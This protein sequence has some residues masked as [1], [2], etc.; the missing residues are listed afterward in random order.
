MSTTGENPSAER[1]RSRD[2]VM[3]M[4]HLTVD[5]VIEPFD[6]RKVQFAD[7]GQRCVQRVV[8][9]PRLFAPRLPL[10]GAQQPKHTCPIE[11]LPITVVAESHGR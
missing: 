10:G 11:S 4:H 2:G 6:V 1:L 7:R 9:R 8:H 3:S 5:D